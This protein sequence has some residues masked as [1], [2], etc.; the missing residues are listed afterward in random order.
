MRAL[1]PASHLST[2]QIDAVIEAAERAVLV[3]CCRRTNKTVYLKAGFGADLPKDFDQAKLKSS[4]AE[5]ELMARAL[6]AD[7]DLNA[8]AVGYD[9]WQSQALVAGTELNFVVGQ[10]L[11]SD[12]VVAIY[13]VATLSSLPAI[14]RVRLLTGA[15]VVMA[16]WDTTPLWAAQDTVGYADEYALWSIQETINVWL[17]PYITVAGGERF[18]LLGVIAEPKGTGPVTK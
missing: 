8:G 7:T 9:Q 1:R 15:A 10:Q 6:L 2:A 14:G 18:M 17:M 4:H 13:G 5:A 11:R 3:E 16:A 12:Q